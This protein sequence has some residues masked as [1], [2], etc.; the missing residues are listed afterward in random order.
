M[1]KPIDRVFSHYFVLHLFI[2]IYSLG[3]VFSKLAGRENFFSFKFC[4]FYGIIILILG[5][6]AIAWQQILKHFDLSTAFCNK[7]I[8]I[9]WGM[10]FGILFFAETIK[11]NMI[12]GAIIVIFG[13]IM[14]VKA[15]E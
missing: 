11:W 3:G 8:T 12:A 14:V 1:N 15:D 4:I 6:Y 10:I 7:A 5:I 2:L 13:V 9:V